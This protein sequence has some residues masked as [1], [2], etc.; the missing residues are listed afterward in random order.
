MLPGGYASLLLAEL[1]ARV[2]KVEEPGVGDYYRAVPHA[3]TLLGNQVGIINQ[4]KESLGL[5]LKAPRGREIFLRLVRKA[6]VVLESFR[7]GVLTRLG[8]GFARLK[9]VRPNI[10]VCSI[11]GFGQKASR[12][13]LAGHDLNFLGLSGLLQRIRDGRGRPVIPDFQIADLAAGYE[14]AMR[15]AAALAGR[16]KAKR[17]FHIDV[18]MEAAALSLSRLY[19][20]PTPLTGELPRYGLYETSDNGWVTLAA[21]EPKFWS[22]F[23]LLIGKPES[24]SRE[25]LEMV[26]RSRTQEEWRQLGLK[27]DL[28]LFPA[29]PA[30]TSAVGRTFPPLGHHSVK[31][32]REI[33]YS[34]KE[35]RTLRAQ[36]VVA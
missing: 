26:F 30:K 31:I 7:P 28:C 9:K 18:S 12:A 21:L 32:L 33:G 1:G 15:I 3:P 5:N 22:K 23:C 20:S 25:E 10:I 27:E 34:L 11:T 14:A 35:S 19:S 6:D 8:L 17:A 16:F 36:G 24:I 29:E 2:I 4:G 13:S